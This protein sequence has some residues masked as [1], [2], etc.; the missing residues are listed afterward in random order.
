M[1]I[2][3]VSFFMERFALGK[4][5]I[6]DLRGIR[7]AAIGKKTSEKLRE[8]NI[9]ADFVPEEY[10]SEV[11]IKGLKKYNLKGK[12]ILIP[13]SLDGRKIL[14]EELEK[15]GAKV[16]DVAI[17]KIKNPNRN[18]RKIKS[19]LKK[20]KIDVIAFTSPSGVKNF[21]NGFK[22]I[23]DY[24]KGVKIASIGPVT[25]NAIEELGMKTDIMPE[26][27][28]IKALAEAIEEYFQQV[29]HL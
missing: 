17:Y 11:L 24:I 25:A 29:N 9:I 23:A 27:Y 2:N 1:A 19:I 22:N 21:V 18:I 8:Y 7:F 4:R 3:S 20:K 16:S 26:E 5:D 6:R 13:R 15:N 14:S 12:E 10:T 28:T